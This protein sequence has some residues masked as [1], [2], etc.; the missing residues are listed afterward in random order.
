MD[1]SIWAVELY[2]QAA[3]RILPGNEMNGCESVASG[4]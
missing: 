4:G 2:K 1:L 3:V